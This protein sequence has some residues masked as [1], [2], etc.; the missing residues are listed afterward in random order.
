MPEG[1]EV[2]PVQMEDLQA[3]RAASLEAFRDHWGFS[4][5]NEPTVEQMVEDPNF[6]PSL[7][8]VAWDGDQVAGMVLS[9]IDARENESYNRLRGWT[10]NIC[11]RRPWRRRGSGAG[12]AGAVVARGA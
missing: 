6:D 7:W 4:E 9:F 8:R 11:V 10:E 12:V 2:R 3:I 1:L 5:E